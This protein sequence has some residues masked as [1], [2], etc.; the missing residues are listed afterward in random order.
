MGLRELVLADLQRRRLCWC[1]REP[2]S[3]RSSGLQR[4]MVTGGLAVPCRQAWLNG[5][6]S[7]G[8]VSRFI[9]WRLRPGLTQAVEIVEPDIHDGSR[10]NWPTLVRLPDRHQNTPDLASRVDAGMCLSDT[11][12]RINSVDHGP[13]C[14]PLAEPL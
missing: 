11:V 8:L 4:R 3:T 10:P 13:E 7:F 9:A 12:K 1:E 2:N 5:S 14:A 6:G